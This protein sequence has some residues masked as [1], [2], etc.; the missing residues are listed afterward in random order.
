M[1]DGALGHRHEPMGNPYG[2]IKNAEIVKLGSA[3]ME[4]ARA[5]G[6]P[7]ARE[8]ALIEAVGIL[9]SSPDTAT[10]RNTSS[11]TRRR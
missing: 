10:H 7:T 6:S 2:G 11:T 3:T 1:R 9:Y 4:K 5:T 8:R